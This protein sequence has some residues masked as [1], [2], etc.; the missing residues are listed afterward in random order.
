MVWFPA[1]HDNR[2]RSPVPDPECELAH[3]DLGPILAIIP[4]DRMNETSLSLLNRLCRSP[5]A[6]SWN[7]LVD[8]Y[9]PLLRAWLRKYDVQD[10][11]ADDLVQ[12]ILIAVMKDLNTFEHGGHPGA[13]RGWLRAILINRLR[14]FWRGRGRR[15]QARGGSDLERRLAELEDPAGEMSRIWN[16]EH[17]QYVA[18]RLLAAVETQFAPKTWQAF[19][20]TALEGARADVVAAELGM[21]VNA[22]FIAKSRVLSRLRQEADGLVES[23]S[24]FLANS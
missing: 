23:S 9:A 12:E 2:S 14:N 6:E 7:R 18:R 17:D 15:P 11:D 16:R 24:N 13:F 19:A 10:A 5:E 22:V 1:K 21:S 3:R 20:R 8:L 4:W